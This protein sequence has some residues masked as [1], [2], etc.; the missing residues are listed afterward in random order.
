MKKVSVSLG[1]RSYSIIMDKPLRELAKYAAAKRLGQ[2]FFIVTNTVVAKRYLNAVESGFKFID[3]AVDCAIIPDGEQFKTLETVEK[4]YKAAYKAGVDRSTCVVALGGGVV[5]DIAGFFAATYLR[6]LPCIQVPTTLLAMVDSSVGGKTGVDLPGGKNLVG[7]FHQPKLVWIDPATLETLPPRHLRNGMAEV[8]KYGIIKD[9]ALFARLEKM[10]PDNDTA[11]S[12]LPSQLARIIFDCCSIKARVVKKDEFETKGLR[13]TLNFGHTFGHALETATRYRDYL[14]G[15]AV[16]I[17]MV[18]AAR[19]AKEMGIL[20]PAHC[21]RIERLISRAGLP[22]DPGLIQSP[23]TPD[24]LVSLM[25]RDKKAKG[26][27]IRLILPIRIGA[28]KAVTFKS[29]K[30]IVDL[31]FPLKSGGKA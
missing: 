19:C 11:A 28:V 25:L 5:G 8:I 4:L 14:H 31:C 27:S 23:V 20:S 9:A 6:G 15:E 30:E 13:E 1:K 21:G 26:G 24:T 16:A 7:A 17:G 10:Y 2:R 3:V 12:L 29:E 22:T 18:M